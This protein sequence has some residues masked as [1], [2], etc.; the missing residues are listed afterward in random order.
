MFDELLNTV[1]VDIATVRAIIQTNEKLRIIIFSDASATKPELLENA[2]FNSLLKVIPNQRNWQ[3]YDHCAVVT[4]LYAI[5]EKF[6]KNLISDW[7]ALL[8]DLVPNYSNLEQSIQQ[9][10]QQGVG[11]LLQELKKNRFQHLTPK[12]VVRGLVL[13]ITTNEKYEL[14]PDAFLLQDQN[15]RKDVLEKLFADAGINNAWTWV[16]NHRNIKRFLEEVRENQNT[17]EGELNQLVSYRNDSAHGLGNEILGTQYL[18]SFGD[19][20]D[21]LCQ[22]L[23]DLVTYR[24]ILEK[25]KTGKAREIG[26]ITEWFKKPKAGVAKLKDIRLSVGNPLFLVNPSI[27]YCQLAKVESIQINDVFQD[28]VEIATETETEVGLKFDIDGK[29]GLSLYVIE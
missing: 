21:V 3:V 20:I 11:R 4:R 12:K 9:T 15:L 6:V 18:L 29:E 16:I 2:E 26:Q 10:H 13:G 7:L 19:F 1:S 14:L 23:A 25:E 17:A 24:V 27:S 22:V 5:Y 8:P 28:E